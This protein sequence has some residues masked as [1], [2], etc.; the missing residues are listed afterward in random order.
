MERGCRPRCA[1]SKTNT[2]GGTPDRPGDGLGAEVKGWA[3]VVSYES[4]ARQMQRPDAIIDVVDPRFTQAIV[5][6]TADEMHRTMVAETATGNH[7][8]RNHPIA[9][10]TR[11]GEPVRG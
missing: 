7:G 4:V 3:P 11:A 2:I 10:P 6:G 1:L 9:V 8:P 5:D